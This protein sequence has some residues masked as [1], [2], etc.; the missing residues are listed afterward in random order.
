ML[1]QT[2]NLLG[3]G[4]CLELSMILTMLSI[5]VLSR[6]CIFFIVILTMRMD[7]TIFQIDGM[8]MDGES[9]DGDVNLFVKLKLKL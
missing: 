1:I 2:L 3:I 9:C 5:F 6:S 7:F 8:Q 4:L